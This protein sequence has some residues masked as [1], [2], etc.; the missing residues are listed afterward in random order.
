MNAGCINEDDL[1]ITLRMNG[2]NSVP[3]RLR[4]AGHYADLSPHDGVDQR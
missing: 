3:R 1:R 4:L 2:K